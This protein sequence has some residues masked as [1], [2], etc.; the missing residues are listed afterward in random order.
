MAPNDNIY[1]EKDY[2]S[3]IVDAK[4]SDEIKNILHEFDDYFNDVFIEI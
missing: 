3:V 2:L 4:Y 1:I